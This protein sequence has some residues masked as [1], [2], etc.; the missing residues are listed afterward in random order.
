MHKIEKIAKEYL[1]LLKTKR[2][3]DKS[4]VD[5]K[6]ELSKECRKLVVRQKHDTSVPKVLAEIVLD[7]LNGE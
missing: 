4:V 5:K 6:V 1:H 3:V 7:F 2:G